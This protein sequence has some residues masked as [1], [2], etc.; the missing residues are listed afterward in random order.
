MNR[1]KV[2]VG[3]GIRTNRLGALIMTSALGLTPVP[4][5]AAPNGQ[6]SFSIVNGTPIE[7]S[8]FPEVVRLSIRT[9]QGAYASCGG[10]ILNE[11]WILTAAHCFEDSDPSTP[12]TVITYFEEDQQGKAVQHSYSTDGQFPHPEFA[13][14]YAAGGGTKGQY[15]VA[16]V[17]TRNPIH[18]PSGKT[19]PVTNLAETGE[20][21]PRA[22]MAT[23]V[24]R[25]VHAWQRYPNIP[26]GGHYV[27]DYKQLRR[28]DVPILQECKSHV[29]LCAQYPVHYH[30]VPL[31]ADVHGSEYRLPNSCYGDS[32][33][34][35]YVE[36]NGTRVQVGLVSHHRTRRGDDIVFEEDVC[37]RA[38][39]WYTSLSY[40]RPWVEA[41]MQA[42]P[43]A[44]DRLP[45]VPLT[46]PREAA[47]MPQPST[48]PAPVPPPAVPP[49]SQP[50]PPVAPPP[51]VP[52]PPQAP[53]PPVVPPVAPTPDPTP[54]APARDH[55]PSYSGDGAVLGQVPAVGPAA[56]AQR[57][58]PSVWAIGGTNPSQGS[59]LAIGVARQRAHLRTQEGKPVLAQQRVAL[60]ASEQVMA[61]A[62]A[63]GPLQRDYPLFLTKSDQLE[64]AV[65]R[66]LQREG[67]SEVW[68][69][70]GPSAISPAVQTAL[71]RANMSTRRIAGANRI[72]TALAIAKV[73]DSADA[74]KRYLARAFGDNGVESRTWAD[75]LAL[76]ALAA[77]TNTPVLLSDTQ[78]LSPGVGTAVQGREV[79][80]VGGP[81][82]LHTS[83][84]DQL[85]KYTART[86]GRIAGASRAETATAIREAFGTHDHLI[87]I[88]GQREDAWQSGFPLAGL[89]SDLNAPIVLT[90]GD[91]IPDSTQAAIAQTPANKVLCVADAPVC[92]K[93]TALTKR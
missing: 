47:P 91:V 13:R 79:T 42:N 45:S 80:L 48:P 93:V 76:G 59:D 26:I 36:R 75:S 86:P 74:G 9:D 58:I 84:Q 21:I 32:G 87:V 4:V 49:P 55:I 77:R 35:I 57:T 46:P 89:A 7:A 34:P 70:G 52:Q 17:R 23:V 39:V 8:D 90:L 38:T 67:I 92:A 56:E 71:Q 37:G 43:K 25:G 22:G 73:A 66:E 64:L 3:L 69:L 2:I 24:G 33:G 16:L 54:E 72:E 5:H 14:D 68:I 15:D 30:N 11:H 41:V 62:L 82:A 40:V 85:A 29:Q 20:P 83:V 12:A 44:G 65:L 81:A 78:T 53:V 31:D 6:A 60:L 61:D 28:A 88:D 1:K 18:V 10:T 27:A 19:L 63:S 51:S 50:V